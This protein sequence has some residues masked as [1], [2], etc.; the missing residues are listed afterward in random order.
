MQVNYKKLSPLAHAPQRAHTT[1]AG[2]DL[3]ATSRKLDDE[4]NIVYGTG[5]AFEIPEGFVGYVFPRS[6]IS[7]Q[8][9]FLTN[10]VGVIDAGYR[11]EVTAKFKMAQKA[12][13]LERE[14]EHFFAMPTFPGCTVYEVGERIAQLII[15]PIPAIEFTEADELSSSERGTGGYGSTGSK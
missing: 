11:G 6:S 3:Y 7:K 10:S 13:C 5:L 9:L 8:N 2:F 1:D 12:G 4:G 14:G 15:M